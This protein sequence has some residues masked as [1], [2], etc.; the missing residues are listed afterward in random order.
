MKLIAKKICL[1]WVGSFVGLF[2][3]TS[4][5]AATQIPNARIIDVI[6]DKD[7]GVAYVVLDGVHT[8][9][10]AC[11]LANFNDRYQIVDLDS[12]IGKAQLSVALVALTS[13]DPVKAVGNGQCTGRPGIENLRLTSF[14]GN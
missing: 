6:A 1:V 9:T 5:L 12:A 10:T 2:G 4:S 8:G 14:D 3:I 11:V 13:G 7:Y